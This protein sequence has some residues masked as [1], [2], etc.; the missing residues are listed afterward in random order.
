[1]EINSS[2]ASGPRI[3]ERLAYLDNNVYGS[4]PGAP[5]VKQL[6]ESFVGAGWRARSSSW[7]QYEVEQDWARLELSQPSLDEALVAGVVDP[8]RLDDL[9]AL[10]AG[11]G[12]RYSLELWDEEHTTVVREV[13]S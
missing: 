12:L 5:G 11:M 2:G 1:M 4:L 8:S 9:A 13:S 3:A 6:A 7:S 10:L